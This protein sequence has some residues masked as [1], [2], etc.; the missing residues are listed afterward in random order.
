[1]CHLWNSLC[2]PEPRGR[3]CSRGQL[4]PVASSSSRTSSPPRTPYR[5]LEPSARAKG[6]PEFV[7]CI[8]QHC[9]QQCTHYTAQHCVQNRI[10]HFTLYEH[11]KTLY[12]IQH[13]KTFKI[14]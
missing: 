3:F 14:V 1:M 9:G 5:P 6:T 10:E 2:D 7:I 4:W 13:C 11:C 8:I 12:N